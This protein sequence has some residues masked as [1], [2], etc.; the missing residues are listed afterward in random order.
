MSE[1]MVTIPADYVAIPRNEYDRMTYKIDEYEL[2]SQKHIEN[3]KKLI[4]VVFKEFKNNLK[5]IGRIGKYPTI[6]VQKVFEIFG[7]DMQVVIDMAEEQF[8]AESESEVEE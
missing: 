4:D 5:Y 6:D 7:L 1:I 8:K 3:R 2:N